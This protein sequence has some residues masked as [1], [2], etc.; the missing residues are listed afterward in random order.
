MIISGQP[1][2]S[3]RSRRRKKGP[4]RV[5]NSRRVKKARSHG[6]R[7]KQLVQRDDGLYELL[8]YTPVR[9]GGKTVWK[10]RTT[11]KTFRK[12]QLPQLNLRG[13]KIGVGSIEGTP[14]E[15]PVNFQPNLR[16]RDEEGSR[17]AGVDMAAQTGPDLPSPDL[18]DP[19]VQA[20]IESSKRPDL[21]IF[22]PEQLKKK[23]RKLRYS[24]ERF[25]SAV[26][27]VYPHAQPVRTSTSSGTP[28][29]FRVPI[30]DNRTLSLRYLT[31]NPFGNATEEI[32]GQPPGRVYIEFENDANTGK[33]PYSDQ[34]DSLRPGSLG[35]MRSFLRLGK[36]LHRHGLGVEMVAEPRRRRL[37]EKL[38]RRAGYEPD[39]LRTGLGV[40]HYRPSRYKP[41]QPDEGIGPLRMSLR[42]S[43]VRKSG[44]HSPTGGVV[45]RGL[46]YPGGKFIPNSELEKARHDQWENVNRQRQQIKY[47]RSDGSVDMS[48]AIRDNP[49][50]G[51][52]SQETA[53]SKLR[54]GADG[55]QVPGRASSHKKL[56]PGE[57]VQ[58]L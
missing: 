48:Q 14:Y 25:A 5:R 11:G 44:V 49:G 27:Q 22:R 7:R 37:Y 50:L 38:L 56:G 8:V 53:L 12:E 32:P 46:F 4:S 20:F 1:H 55:R 26:Q 31:S 18:A 41:T 16:I 54:K 3:I 39:T 28:K 57:R 23:G 52:S 30:E 13:H 36:H 29:Q 17:P 42:G 35:L 47:R 6:R 21:R 51:S 43:K 33:T 9:K 15:P 58:L 34:G 24:A 19:Q 2:P 10:G 45:V 40:M